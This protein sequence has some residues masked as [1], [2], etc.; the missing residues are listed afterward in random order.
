MYTQHAS[1]ELPQSCSRDKAPSAVLS[2]YCK[3]EH[4]IYYTNVLQLKSE[5]NENEQLNQNRYYKTKEL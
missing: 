4:R 3:A 1:V 2:L 5:K